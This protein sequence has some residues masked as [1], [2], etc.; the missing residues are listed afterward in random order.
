MKS[1][2]SAARNGTFVRWVFFEVCLFTEKVWRKLIFSVQA[3]PSPCL[4]LTFKHILPFQI[5]YQNPQIQSTFSQ[6]NNPPHPPL[7]FSES[8]QKLQR[9][10]EIPF[11]VQFNPWSIKFIL[12]NKKTTNLVSSS[13]KEGCFIFT[14][15]PRRRPIHRCLQRKGKIQKK[16][17]KKN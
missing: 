3:P 10:I 15:E 5:S 2:P 16:K 14:S 13:P 17:K 11:R 9:N 12:P 7:T 8:K 6:K 4:I 1:P